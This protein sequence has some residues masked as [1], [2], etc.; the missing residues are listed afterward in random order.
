M[1]QY[2]KVNAYLLLCTLRTQIHVEPLLQKAVE[3][4]NKPSIV[5]SILGKYNKSKGIVRMIVNTTKIALF[6]LLM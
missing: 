3:C 1:Y 4:F 6:V 2:N 5:L